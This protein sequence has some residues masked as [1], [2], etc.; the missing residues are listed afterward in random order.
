M[1]AKKIEIPKKSLEEIVDELKKLEDKIE[2]SVF[3]L[4]NKKID[5]I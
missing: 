2:L 5:T 4:D 3:K 1:T